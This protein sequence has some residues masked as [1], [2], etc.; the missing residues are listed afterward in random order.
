MKQIFF[1]EDKL[2]Q[3]TIDGTSFTTAYGKIY[4]D[5]LREA[6]KSFDSAEKT[7]KE[8]DKLIAKKIKSGYQKLRLHLEDPVVNRCKLQRAQDEQPTSFRIDDDCSEAFI[9]EICKIEALTE[10]KIAVKDKLPACIGQLQNLEELKIRGEHVKYLPD[11]LGELS[12]LKKLSFDYTKS[13]VTIPNAI[14]K[15]DQLKE[16]SISHTGISA[17][18]EDIGQLQALEKL[19][20]EYNFQLKHYPPSFGQL[21]SLKKLSITNL[22]EQYNPTPTN[23]SSVLPEDIGSLSNLEELHLE[24]NELT[25]LPDSIVQLKQ[26]KVLALDYNAFTEIPKG[27]FQL[28]HLKKLTLR[29]STLTQIP[30]QLCLLKNLDTFD[31]HSYHATIEN[32]PDVILEGKN[33]PSIQKHLMEHTDLETL[34]EADQA[35]LLRLRATAA[36]NAPPPIELPIPPTNKTALVAARKEQ[37]EKFIR[38]V[39]SRAGALTLTQLEELIAYLKGETSTIPTAHP[40]GE[41]DFEDIS[42]ILAPLE[43]WNFIDQRI[44]TFIGQS[45][46][47]YQK[48]NYYKGYHEAFARYV[49]QQLLENPSHPTLYRDLVQAVA[50][51]GL[52]EWTLLSAIFDELTKLPLLTEDKQPT[53][54][55]HYVLAYFEQHPKTLVE[56]VLK[57]SHATQFAALMVKYNESGLQP[58]LSQLLA[59]KEY[60]GYDGNK[61]LPFLTLDAL[62]AADFKYKPYVLEAIAATDCLSC[63]MECYRILCTHDKETYGASTLEKIK[64]TLVHISTKKNGGERYQFQWSAADTRWTDDTAAFIDWACGHFGEALKQPLFEYVENTEVLDLK[65]IKVAV[66]QYGQKALDIAA[67]AL[68]MHIE[69]DSLAT[70]YKTTFSILSSLDFSKYYDKVWEIAQSTFTNVADTACIALSGQATSLIVPTATKL[71]AQKSIPS[72][73]AGAF[74]LALI[75]T[76]ETQALIRPLLATEKN[77]EVRNIVVQALLHSPTPISIAEAQERVASAAAR[78]KLSKPVAKWLEERN[79]PPLV[80]RNKTALTSEETRFLFY[81][82]KSSDRIETDREAR[83]VFGLIDPTSGAKFAKEVWTLLQKNGGAK[84]KNRFAMGVV[85]ALAD[86]QLITPLYTEATSGKNLNAC[87]M[88]G[89]MSSLE[90][91]SALDRIQQFFKVKYPNVRGAAESAFESIADALQLSTF[92]LSDKMLPDLGFDNLERIVT[93]GAEEY[94]ASITKDFKFSYQDNTGKALKS[95]PKADKSVNDTW[96]LLGQN[97]K[98]AVDQLVPNLEFYLVTQRAW[99]YQDWA[100]FFTTNPIAFAAAQNFVWQVASPEEKLLGTFMITSEKNLID[101]QGQ[102]YTIDEPVLIR[103]AHPLLMAPQTL[104]AWTAYVQQQKIEPPF[105]QLSRAVLPVA[106]SMVDKTM[107]YQFNEFKIDGYRF[108]SRA[109]KKGWKRGAVV[110]SGEISSYQKVYP[111]LGIQALLKTSNLNVQSYEEQAQLH[112]FYFVPLGSVE[113]GSYTYN[114]PRTEFD[115][116]LIAFGKVPPIVYS[117]TLADLQIIL[118]D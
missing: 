12:S 62:C 10:L 69:D 96:K 2:W 93:I 79:L 11:E 7:T 42:L 108:K 58:Y 94:T 50:P 84:A 40:G 65:V 35:L 46:F 30:L 41:Y 38:T 98:S 48:K 56:L 17:L 105:A 109:A 39:K 4:S 27:V 3:I 20:I 25:T 72:R 59:V 74:T 13:L 104:A 6:T 114:E 14:G 44:I 80:W 28:E 45:A 8:A 85:A 15:L 90:A 53:S 33:A 82:Q 63:A 22:C 67:E 100:S 26:L 49:E 36:E 77:E 16:L 51:Y 73:R 118:A 81:R 29:N 116:R 87:A 101:H 24:F 86:H 55:G 54:L 91:A 88:L 70:H 71:L 31:C 95:L 47:Y 18:P 75:N 83:E 5:S 37:L 68:N 66:K 103:L 107:D 76:P 61:H 23:P 110:D 92:E 102:P 99:S 52:D 97:L 21:H 60:K 78:G 57:H 9:A 19:E 113:Q 34:N 43:A 106:A 89:V 111:T 1:D 64:E 115:S 112:E 32:V 117:E